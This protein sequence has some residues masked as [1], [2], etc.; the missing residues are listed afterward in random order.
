M[1]AYRKVTVSKLAIFVERAAAF[2]LPP[3]GP[4]YHQGGGHGQ[5]KRWSHGLPQRKLALAED[6]AR[7]GIDE[8]RAL[9]SHEGWRAFM[10]FRARLASESDRFLGSTRGLLHRTSVTARRCCTPPIG[11][12]VR[13]GDALVTFL[14]LTFDRE[15]DEK[16][17]PRLGVVLTSRRPASPRHTLTGPEY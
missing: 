16:H 9:L 3:C 12:S 15:P 7:T 1:V 2:T 10:A 6:C 14:C 8:I 5:S 4:A 13:F 17:E 11:I